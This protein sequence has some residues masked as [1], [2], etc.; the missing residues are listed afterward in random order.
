M[1]KPALLF[2]TAWWPTANTPY[3]GLFV[4][5]HAK[6]ISSFFELYIIHLTINKASTKGLYSIQI[7]KKITNDYI[8][9]HVDI[10]T[11]VRRFGIYNWLIKKGYNRIIKQLTEQHHFVGYHFNIRTHITRFVP[12]LPILKDLSY[13]HT[14]HFT[15]YHNGINMLSDTE[16]TIE[17]AR[18]KKWMKNPK[19]LRIMPVSNELSKILIQKFDCPASKIKV[20]PNIASDAFYYSPATRKNN[21]IR[22]LA[23]ASWKGNKRPTQLLEAIM[24]LP[25]EVQK[26]LELHFVGGGELLDAAMVFQKEKLKDLDVHYHGFQNKEYIAKLIPA[27]DFLVHPTVAENSPTII[28]EALCAGLPVLSMNVNG[29]PELVNK[30]NGILVESNDIAKFSKGILEMIERINE[31]NREEISKDALNK[32]SSRVIGEQIAN[33]LRTLL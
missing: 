12:Y 21:I 16:K 22:L 8:V 13:L 31:F 3:E 29:V 1:Q 10:K 14:E 2:F 30:S 27:S 24:L 32:F 18:I 28:T 6:S 5:E 4:E 7:E 20:I 17:I 9:Y 26:K 11:K 25:F 19:M 23:A 15:Y 33:E